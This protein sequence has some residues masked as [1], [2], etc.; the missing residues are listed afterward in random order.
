MNL[1][2]NVSS[3][4]ALPRETEW[5]EFKQHNDNPEEIGEYI[6][7][8]ANSAALFGE[9]A[10]YLIWGID[11]VS[12]EVVGTPV[13]PHHG[14]VGNEDMQNWLAHLLSP[15]V[16]FRFHE[17]IKDEKRVLVLTVQP[18]SASPVAFKGT[19]WIR[20]GSCKKKLKDHPGREKELWI[21]LNRLCFE[22][23][24]AAVGLT[25]EQVLG[26]LDCTKFFDLLHQSFPAERRSILER[27]AEDR[28][29]ISRGADHF[30][31]TNLGAL[32]FAK[33]LTDFEGF[34]RKALRV[35][36]YKGQDRS[37]TDLEKVSNVGYAAGFE[38]IISYINDLAPR[39]EVLGQALRR[40]VRMYPELAIR[41]LVANALI[42]QDF[43]VSGTGPM[44]EVFEDRMEI[45]NPGTPLIDPLRFIDHSPRSRN[46][47]L[48]DLLR[49]LGICEERGSGFDKVISAIEAFQLPPP[50]IR[51]DTTHT[52][53]LLFA[54]K[55]L[56][57]MD[58]KD[59]IR[60]CYQH[61][62]LL[63][64]SNKVMT[65]TTLR[66]RFKISEQDY[67]MASR[68]IR[69]TM[70]SKLVKPADPEGKSRK[71]AKYVPIW[72]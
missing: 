3:L 65:N 58:K 46:E 1:D 6:S 68:I 11:N 21:A 45:S 22:K 55:D 9:P 48:A 36:K 71:H 20:I 16:D 57:R 8:L 30:D 24:F 23:G 69:E 18:S 60:A 49:R 67:P 54:H 51:I 29:V 40:D 47:V 13:A 41:E 7:A 2:R 53:L 44:V 19:E 43:S 38:E 52:R 50:D 32:L 15:R 64:V 5:V 42:H 28:L 4:L 72:A 17:I 25:G 33:R 37:K 70:V 14:K 34:R 59:R 27:L 31:V 10:G 39:N 66:E 62:C 61:C 12:R 63:Y 56:Q 35:I 26:V